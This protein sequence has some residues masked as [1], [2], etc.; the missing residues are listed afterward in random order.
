MLHAHLENST[1]TQASDWEKTLVSHIF[2]SFIHST[3]SVSFEAHEQTCWHSQWRMAIEKDSLKHSAQCS[4]CQASFSVART[5][6]HVFGVCS[7]RWYWVKLENCFRAKYKTKTCHVFFIRV[8]KTQ[9]LFDHSSHVPREPAHA[10]CLSKNAFECPRSTPTNWQWV[11]HSFPA[12]LRRASSLCTY[13]SDRMQ[14]IHTPMAHSFQN[15]EF[16]SPNA[17]VL[18]R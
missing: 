2:H 5:P 17:S 4:A 7:V 14:H 1:L 12:R 16:N 11:F 9:W 18:T 15:F 13:G 6:W 8:I 3:F 10:R